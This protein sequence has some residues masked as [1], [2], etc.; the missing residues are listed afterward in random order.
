MALLTK[1]LGIICL[2][3]G[4]DHARQDA[5]TGNSGEAAGRPHDEGTLTLTDAGDQ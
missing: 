5:D 3:G 2:A 1:C 4:S